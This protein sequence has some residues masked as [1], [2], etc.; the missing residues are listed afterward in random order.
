MA[1]GNSI[2]N[3]FS[4]DAIELDPAYEGL[5]D[6]AV[7]EFDEFMSVACEGDVCYDCDYDEYDDDD[8]DIIFDDDEDEDDDD[9]D[10][11]YD[12]DDE[13]EE[14]VQENA[15]IDATPEQKRERYFKMIDANPRFDADKKKEMKENYDKAHPEGLSGA[16]ESA[17][18]YLRAKHMLDRD[19][20]TVTDDVDDAYDNPD[21]E[22]NEYLGSHA[23]F[24]SD[25]GTGYARLRE[26]MDGINDFV[27]DKTANY[28]SNLKTGYHRAREAA[29][30][31]YY[32]DYAVAQESYD[33]VMKELNGGH[34]YNDAA[35]SAYDK[36]ALEGISGIDEIDVDDGL[37]NC[38]NALESMIE[39]LDSLT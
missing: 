5:Y 31:D 38:R 9:D 37:D 13:E 29:M 26:R 10:D 12:E 28:A 8:D 11:E 22:E 32:N 33:A 16:K 30:D 25:L 18:D 34:Y 1:F 21:Y 36:M 24:A 27:G 4:D 3:R 39:E 19:D 2:V 7:T 14:C 15:I 17:A 20:D 35:L 23:R 6:T